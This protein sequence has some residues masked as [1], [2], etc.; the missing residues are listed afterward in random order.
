M[1]IVLLFGL[2]LTG[3][4]AVLMAR[5]AVMQRLRAT[6]SVGRI[7]SYGFTSKQ[8]DDGRPGPPPF[9]RDVPSRN[10]SVAPQVSELGLSAGEKPS[11][12]VYK[13]PGPPR[14]N[15]EPRY[16]SLPAS[17]ADGFLARFT[18]GF[19]WQRDSTSAR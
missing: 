1:L 9:F 15:T 10:H 13:R 5:A 18:G 11:P 17:E 16:G 14:V 3:A 2:A 12:R 7:G 4:S 8:A 6:E 19:T